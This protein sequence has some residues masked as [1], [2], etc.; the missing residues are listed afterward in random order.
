MVHK[1]LCQ[2]FKG[3]FQHVK[4]QE[5][6]PL[7][8]N[9]DPK[10]IE[11]LCFH[12][13][14]GRRFQ[15]S[16]SFLEG[17]EDQWAVVLLSLSLEPNRILTWY[18]LACLSKTLKYKQR[19][20]LHLLLDPRT[21]IVCQA[22]QFLSSLLL[23]K[24]GEGR[25]ILLWGHFGFDSYQEFCSREIGKCRKIRRILM[26]AAGWIYRRHYMYLNG[27]AFAITMC[28]DDAAHPETLQSFCDFWDCKHSCCVPPGLCRDWKQMGL[29]SEELCHGNARSVLYWLAATIQ[30]SIADIESMHSQNRSLGGNAFSSIAAKFINC[31]AK[32]VAEDAV[33]LQKSGEDQGCSQKRSSSYVKRGGILVKDTASAPAKAKGMS[34]LELFR[35]HMI[36]TKKATGE[37]VNPCS[38]TFWEEVKTAY[39]NLAPEQQRL[40]QSLSDESKSQAASSRCKSR[41]TCASNS[42]QESRPDDLGDAEP[43]PSSEV[44]AHEDSRMPLHAQVLPLHELVDILPANGISELQQAVDKELR[45]DDSVLGTSKHPLSDSV[46]ERVWRAQLEKGIT[47]KGFY[48]SF[49]ADAECI[50]RPPSDD[51]VFPERVVHESYC[52]EQCRHHDDRTRIDLHCHTLELCRAIVV[53]K[54][55]YC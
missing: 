14:N 43:V 44:V 7:D 39:S 11:T 1:W 34:P 33:N 47:G 51:D 49:V 54:L 26:L 24:T 52:G 8:E 46:L 25:L 17:P 23:S 19:P 42:A 36:D 31:E 20:P 6:N 18:W 15:S 45:G 22:L 5:Y 9:A 48:K 3:A 4:F 16:V 21:S 53:K 40:F 37:T 2:V 38:K 10:L 30:C 35:K 27:D 13:V 29:T 55:R 50:A 12:M 28:G 32:R 41:K